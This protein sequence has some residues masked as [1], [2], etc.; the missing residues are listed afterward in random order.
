MS[1]ASGWGKSNMTHII[2]GIRTDKHLT[3]IMD[4]LY[5]R[6]ALVDLVN[7]VSIFNDKYVD[8]LTFKQHIQHCIDNFLRFANSSDF[9]MQVLQRNGIIIYNIGEIH[10]DLM[11]FLTRNNI[12]IHNVNLHQYMLTH[13]SIRGIF[14]AGIHGNICVAEHVSGVHY[15]NPR[16]HHYFLSDCIKDLKD[17]GNGSDYYCIWN[18]H[19]VTSLD[20]NCLTIENSI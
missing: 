13:P 2:D 10:Q 9:A 6:I 5:Y 18:W 15:A 8:E 4:P 20:S 12:A 16:I 17:A 7:D 11:Q 1:T 3:L 14:W 19:F